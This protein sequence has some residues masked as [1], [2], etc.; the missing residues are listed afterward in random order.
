MA[1]AY[2]IQTFDSGNAGF[3]TATINGAAQTE[4]GAPWS[5]TGGFLNGHIYAGVDN[6]ADKRYAFAIY[7]TTAIYG[8]LNGANLT[9]AFKTEGTINTLNPL[10][11]FY[12]GTYTGGYN[13]FVSNDTYSWNPNTD[14]NW[15]THSLNVASSNFITWPNQNA[16]TKTFAQVMSGY[17]DIGL[18]FAGGSNF[19][20]EN[21][22]FSSS[23]GATLR[24][25][26]FGSA[27]P[28]PAAVWLLGSG[29]VGLVAL[30]RKFRP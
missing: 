11:R 12:V 15:T 20:N 30:K 26:N 2:S 27:V 18:V 6:S 25:D 16:G 23:A 9:T 22:G 5:G 28:I 1:N 19:N 4:I 7:P 8:D 17:E 24:V 14:T 3:N 13:Y 10:V 21:L 29:L